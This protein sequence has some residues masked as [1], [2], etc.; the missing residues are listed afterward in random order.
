MQNIPLNCTIARGFAQFV[1]CLLIF[2]VVRSLQL[3][4][5]YSSYFT[6]L[7]RWHRDSIFSH[8][9]PW[10]VCQ[11]GLVLGWVV[12]ARGDGVW[13]SRV[14]KQGWILQ[15]NIVT[16]VTAV[17][18]W[19][20]PLANTITLLMRLTHKNVRHRNRLSLI[21]KAFYL[22][23]RCFFV[24]ISSDAVAFPGRDS[25]DLTSPITTTLDHQPPQQ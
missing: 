14:T 13:L 1:L 6:K 8:W 23:F 20:P 25:F 10:M 4:S 7:K 11:Q 18:L 12:I 22:K 17:F 19:R 3:K 5:N 15:S 24:R 21:F 2:Q 16:H 9:P